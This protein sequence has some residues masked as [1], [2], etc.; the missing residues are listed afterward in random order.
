[1]AGNGGDGGRGGRGDRCL[2]SIQIQVHDPRPGRSAE[3]KIGWRGHQRHE[4]AAAAADFPE[5]C[6]TN[7]RADRVRQS[8]YYLEDFSRPH[9]CC[10]CCCCFFLQRRSA[11]VQRVHACRSVRHACADFMTS[12]LRCVDNKTLHAQAFQAWNLHRAL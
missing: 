10:C 2:V 7:T 3:V 4:A 9:C 5:F 11:A 1:M 8:K 6:G 12:S